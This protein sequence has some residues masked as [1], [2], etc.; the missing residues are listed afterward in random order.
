MP[1]WGLQEE[2]LGRWEGRG[3]ECLPAPWQRRSFSCQ[4]QLSKR[5]LLIL[6]VGASVLQ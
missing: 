5:Q 2:K 1:A 4:L 3:V 6:A